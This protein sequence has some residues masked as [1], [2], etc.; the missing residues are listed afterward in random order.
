MLSLHYIHT[1]QT[2][3]IFPGMTRN[4]NRRNIRQIIEIQQLLPSAGSFFFISPIQLIK[5]PWFQLSELVGSAIRKSKNERHPA[6]LE[7]C[8]TSTG[9]AGITGI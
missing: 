2:R 4:L 8:L 1:R 6:P 3:I 9:L 7:G 5:A